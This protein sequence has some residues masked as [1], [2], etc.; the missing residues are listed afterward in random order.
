MRKQYMV[1]KDASML[2][3]VIE[4]IDGNIVNITK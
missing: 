4:Y 2:Y 3:Q 1:Q